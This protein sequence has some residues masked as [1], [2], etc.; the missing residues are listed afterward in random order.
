MNLMKCHGFREGAFITFIISHQCE[1]LTS[2]GLCSIYYDPD[3]PEIC[4][5]TF[6]MS[7]PCMSCSEPKSVFTSAGVMM[8][9]ECGSIQEIVDGQET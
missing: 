4:K 7:D 1:K 6:C 3:R 2:E 9:R 8:C 5:N